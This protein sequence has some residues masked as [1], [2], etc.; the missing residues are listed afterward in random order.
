MHVL[1]L[2]EGG[3]RGLWGS[4]ALQGRLGESMEGPDLRLLEREGGLARGI[5][6]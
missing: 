6:R 1:T 3:D 2:G 5:S 4:L